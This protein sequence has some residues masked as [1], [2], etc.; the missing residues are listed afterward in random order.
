[1]DAYRRRGVEQTHVVHADVPEIAA[2][3]E[4]DSE[5]CACF[6][7]LVPALKGEYADLIRAVDLGNEPLNRRRGASGSRR[8]TSRCVGIGRGRRCAASSRRPAEPAPTTAAS[9]APAGGAGRPRSP[10]PG[11]KRPDGQARMRG[12]R[13]S[14]M[15]CVLR[16]EDARAIGPSP[17]TVDDDRRPRTLAYP[18]P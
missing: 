1:V 10:S 14:G 3:P 15:I 18:R 7:R 2:E 5:L 4:D 8:T 12:A 11:P 16:V 17:V 9:T 13:R 6:E